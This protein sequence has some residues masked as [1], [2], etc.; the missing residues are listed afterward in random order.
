[1]VKLPVT[2]PGMYGSQLLA[3]V[4]NTFLYGI[5]FLMVLQ[6]FRR[7][8]KHDPLYVKLIVGML[9]TLTTLETAFTAHQAYDNFILKFGKKELFNKIP[10]SVPGK[11]ECVFIATFIAQTFFATR[12][13]ILSNR[14]DPRFRYV[15]IFVVLLGGLQ[16]AAGTG[17][18]GYMIQNKTFSQLGTH[19]NSLVRVVAMQG[20]A[21]TACDITVTVT[22]CWLYQAYRK[23]SGF[24]EV[25][26]VVDK[27]ITYAINRAAATSI[28][29]VASVLLYY[30]CS[31]TYYFMIPLLATGHLYLIS[32]VSL[33]SSRESLR[34]E[35][36]KGR[37]GK[38]DTPTMVES[39]SEKQSM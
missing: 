12:I 15:S 24:A 19:T 9:I 32:V 20:G 16:L 25:A 23:S 11:Y 39:D 13:W 27:L 30:F 22:L 36:D 6:Y 2:F 1:M 34:E 8:A 17:Q 38:L 35:L 10:P 28:C 37:T 26:S 14:F 21:T 3:T 29:A 7:H 31:G 5:G 4:I 33:L 18:V